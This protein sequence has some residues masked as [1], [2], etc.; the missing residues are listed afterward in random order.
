MTLV[1]IFREGT[2]FNTG[3]AVSDSEGTGAFEDIPD[4]WNTLWS[5]ILI[6]DLVGFSESAS[7]LILQKSINL[8]I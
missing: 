1:K 2:F 4:V 5:S 6:E 7:P 3:K 8:I